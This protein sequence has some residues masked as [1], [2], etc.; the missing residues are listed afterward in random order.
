[1][2]EKEIYQ[3]L[4]Q[5]R[6][7]GLSDM[8][9]VEKLKNQ[10]WSNADIDKIL[11]GAYSQSS[12]PNPPPPRKPNEEK[13]FSPAEKFQKE[14]GKKKDPLEQ[15]MGN[16]KFSGH[17]GRG[18]F[19]LMLSKIKKNW[20]QV[21]GLYFLI[22]VCLAGIVFTP[23]SWPYISFIFTIF[24]GLVFFLSVI[25]I[26]RDEWS[27]RSAF[28]DMFPLIFKYLYTMVVAFLALIG[29]FALLIIPGITLSISLTLLP[30]VIINEDKYGM[31]AVIRANELA[32]G[33]RWKI[34]L[35]SLLFQFVIS[36]I[37]G[38]I[39]FGMV[40]AITTV[41]KSG[42]YLLDDINTYTL[43]L[44]VSLIYSLSAIASLI[45]YK[46]FYDELAYFK[47]PDDLIRYEA[48]AHNG[49]FYVFSL[50]IVGFLVFGFYIYSVFS[51][52]GPLG[53][54]QNLINTQ[55]LVETD[56]ELSKMPFTYSAPRGFTNYSNN[57]YKYGYSSTFTYDVPN[58]TDKININIYLEENDSELTAAE[59]L[60]NDQ[61][62]INT[63][64]DASTTLS[65]N[66][67]AI[68]GTDG[69]YI[70]Q[71]FKFI[72]NKKYLYKV[73]YVKKDYIIEISLECDTFYSLDY[74]K[75]FTQSLSSF[76]M[77]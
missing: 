41:S 77:K 49:R 27:M 26:S 48:T 59:W 54:R 58:T 10:G 6:E 32:K 38:L 3:W 2:G 16:L 9:I 68:D 33:H 65:E 69:Y 66:T 61:N 44:F 13:I 35:Y 45:F 64:Y 60:E 15:H 52:I 5:A 25:M 30:Y 7:A 11:V 14:R 21:L 20:R 34:F 43:I 75:D 36:L 67:Y 40:L 23:D 50:L 18:S 73:A 51:G 1:M 37:F 57:E 70:E 42:N 39:I 47:P 53:Q 8:K 46:S 24:T 17:I 31:A 62:I 55:R 74:K 19:G 12:S 63:I 22:T 4:H 56:I 76:R 28:Q 71:T 29:G 72:D